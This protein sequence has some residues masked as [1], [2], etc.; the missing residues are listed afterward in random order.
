MFFSDCVKRV[1]VDIR[2]RPTRDM[3]GA[4]FAKPLTGAKFWRLHIIIMNCGHDE[5]DS[6][7]TTHENT[8]MGIQIKN[9]RHKMRLHITDG[10][11]EVCWE[12]A[13][14]VWMEYNDV[15]NNVY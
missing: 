11:T 5:P 9:Y 13:W 6:V 15:M 7:G 2:Y 4:F 8:Y 12:C 3:V 14:C 10:V 1:H